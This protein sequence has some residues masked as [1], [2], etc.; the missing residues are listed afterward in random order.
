[1]TDPLERELRSMLDE[2]AHGDPGTARRL[3]DGI[4]SFPSRR[5]WGGGFLGSIASA[6]LFVGVVVVVVARLGGTGGQLPTPSPTMTSNPSHGPTLPGGPEAFAGD[7]RLAR[8]SLGPIQYAFVMDHA[9]DYQTYFPKMGISPELDV[10]GSA[11]V[12]VFEAGM[13]QPPTSGLGPGPTNEPGHRYVCVLVDGGDPNLYGDVDITGLTIDVTPSEVSPSATPTDG[14]AATPTR[15][16]APAP[17]WVADLAGQLQ[18]SGGVANVGGEV[19]NADGVGAAGLSPEAGLAS[20]LG[21]ANPY[22]SLPAAGYAQVHLGTDWASFAHVY[23]GRTKAIVILSDVSE[24]G[25]GWRVVGLRACDASEFDPS[26][27][28]T[29]PVTVWTDRSGQP[30]STETIRSSPGPGHCGWDSAIWLQVGGDLYFRDPAGVMSEWTTTT[31]D[32]AAQL[33]SSAADT[34]FR[35]G[36]WSLWIDPGKDAYVVSTDRVE[37]WPRSKDPLIGCI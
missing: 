29:F 17:V 23:L 6:V 9:R 13:A 10:D 8:C 4:A 37:R 27:P 14:A 15:T 33:P 7:P 20:F 2:R 28:L 11:F 1:M 22:A 30:V 16:L 12:A 35:T 34:G 24:V 5:R 3:A 31:F 32:S 19:P 26:V 25:G 36:S 18:C 21:P